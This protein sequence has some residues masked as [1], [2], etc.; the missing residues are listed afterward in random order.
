[1][2]R[3]VNLAVAATV[4]LVAMAVT[5]SITMVISMDMFNNTV[6]SVKSKERMY[7]KLSEIDRYVRD[8]EY[9]DINEDTL[10][11]T[12]ASGY[13]LGISDKYARYYSAKAYTE[14]VGVETGRLMNIGV[15][16]IKD[17]SSGYARIIRVYDNSPAS[18]IGLQVGGFITNIGDTNV[19]TMTDTAAINSAL[20]G[21]EGTTVSITYL[22]PDRQEQPAVELVRS[23][24][25][26][27]TVFTQL[28]DDGCGYVCIDAFSATTGTEFRTAV[29]NLVNQGAKALVF[30]LRNN[31][32]DSLDAAL[33]AADYCVPA[34]LMAQSQAKDGTLTDLRISDDHEI[35]IPMVC[36]VNGNTAG[37]AELFANAL[38]KMAGAS[39][40]GTTT[41]GKGVVLSEPQSFSDGSAAVITTGLLLDNEGQTW[42]GTGL[43]PDIEATLTADE[44]N[45]YYDFTVETDPQ[46]NKAVT[47]VMAMVG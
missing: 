27:T 24:Y 41:A 35:N 23:N 34:G 8:N 6:S 17:A 5:F 33:V 9:F 47:S 25:T 21:E 42:N 22:N 13:M 29:E 38:R 46:I 4:T 20:L 36:L 26:T 44:Q 43:T 11:D 12:I 3:K 1:M 28:T 40:V 19:R 7:N 16:V 10:N 15:S 32:G 37:G 39:I 30:D 45:S 14:K 31:T 2:S 18:E